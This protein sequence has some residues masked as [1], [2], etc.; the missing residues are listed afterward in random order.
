M[1]DLNQDIVLYEDSIFGRVGFSITSSTLKYIAGSISSYCLERDIPSIVIGTDASEWSKTYMQEVLLPMLEDLQLTCYFLDDPCPLF[2]LSWLTQQVHL[3]HNKKKFLGIYLS[4]DSYYHD[5][6]SISFRHHDGKPF[7]ELQVAEL[8]TFGKISE[9]AYSGLGESPVKGTAL[10]ISAYPNYLT[11]SK[12]INVEK[13][14]N[15]KVHIDTMFGCTEA[16]LTKIGKD[17][18]FCRLNLWNLAAGPERVRNYVASPT[19]TA[20][21]WRALNLTDEPNS[22][23][24]A[25]NN[26]GTSL[27][28]WDLRQNLEISKSGT[29]M[30]LIYHAHKILKKR[31]TVLISKAVSGRVTSLIESLGLNY[32][33]VDSGVN[34]FIEAIEKKRRSPAL[35]YGDE[36]GKFWFKGDVYDFNP[37]IAAMRITELCCV[38]DKSPGQILDDLQ[39][40]LN[41]SYSYSNLIL[42]LGIKGKFEIQEEFKKGLSVEPDNPLANTHVYNLLDGVSKVAVQE[43]V[44][45]SSVEVFIE[46][47]DNETTKGLA[48]YVQELFVQPVDTKLS[49]ANDK[50]G[51]NQP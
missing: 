22:L 25:F 12:L 40:H 31:G 23:F 5:R 30:L 46:S 21:Q 11:D 16:L 38:L 20:L 4:V 7:S 13:T 8:C 44:R 24:F 10:D 50:Q 41:N 3:S 39:S 26:T 47:Q 27:G 17:M 14:A 37:L 33:I 42:P 36:E 51:S 6:L 15:K 34:N 45:Q 29:F 49:P 32:E 19:G 2:Q 18:S 9:D 48:N 28:V 35:M 1:K 43:N